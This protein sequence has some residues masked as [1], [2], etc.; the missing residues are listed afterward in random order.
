MAPAPMEGVEGGKVLPDLLELHGCNGWDPEKG[1]TSLWDTKEH[2]NGAAVLCTES[3]DT[4]C[5]LRGSSCS[6]PGTRGSIVS[7]Y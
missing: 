4:S 1:D 6:M 7:C 3:R 5:F 2:I